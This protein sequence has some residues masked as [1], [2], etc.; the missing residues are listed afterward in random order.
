MDTRQILML[1]FGA[2]GCL[3]VATV[4]GVLLP[5]DQ[6]SPILPLM[7]IAAGLVGGGLLVT[8]LSHKTIHLSRQLSKF[9][10]AAAESERLRASLESLTKAMASLHL[11]VDDEGQIVYANESAHRSFDTEVIE[12]RMI[13]AATM[14]PELEEVITQVHGSREPR[15][16]EIEFPQPSAWIGKVRA[17]PSEEASDQVN[18]TIIDVTKLRRLERVRQDFVANVS[19]ELRTPMATIRVLTE[20]SQDAETDE[21]RLQLSQQVL[22]EIDR[23]TSVTDDLLVLGKAESLEPSTEQCDLAEIASNAVKLMRSAAADKGL[24]LTADLPDSAPLTAD[25]TQMSQVVINLI[26]NA[27]ANT[28]SGAVE[29]A[30]REAADSLELLVKDTGSGIE[31][32]HLPRIFERFYRVD[33][34]RTRERGGTGLGLAIVRNI[35]ESHGGTISAESAPQQGSTFTVTLPAG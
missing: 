17:W 11:V 16:A 28:E 3:V 8:G 19:H 1:R 13:V 9:Q 20:S 15:E 30:I 32:E 26:D 21:E 12:G 23:L 24:D 25:P 2:L 33:K 6:I 14:S 29:V 5:S 22:R 35:V 10:A 18:V 34:G 31:S 4:G 7:L 27:I